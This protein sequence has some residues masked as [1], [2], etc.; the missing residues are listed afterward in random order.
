MPRSRL[1]IWLTSGAILNP[2]RCALQ[3]TMT[4]CHS[5]SAPISMGRLAPNL[6]QFD[7]LREQANLQIKFHLVLLM[8]F[9]SSA[10]EGELRCRVMA[11][12]TNV[13]GWLQATT[14]WLGKV[15]SPIQHDLRFVPSTKTSTESEVS[16]EWT[17]Y[18]ID[19]GEASYDFSW[20]S[21]MAS[22]FA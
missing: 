3:R 15:W 7:L 5:S 21:V 22:L 2:D 18:W 20:R 1:Q 13:P 6:C 9:K 12:S 19:L 8:R 11:A 4:T 10:Q 16:L 14:N 17:D